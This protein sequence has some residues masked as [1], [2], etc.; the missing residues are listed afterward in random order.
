MIISTKHKFIF[1]HIPKT[2]GTSIKK[3]LAPFYN[4]KR[5]L[6]KV[7]RGLQKPGIIG[8]KHSPALLLRQ[9]VGATVWK[10]Y[11][12]FAFVR[13]PWDWFVSAYHF[14]RKNGRDPRQP[15]VLKRS[16][17]DFVPWFIN[18]EPPL[19]QFEKPAILNGQHWYVMNKRC[20]YMINFIG[21]LETFQEDFS[22]V[23][24][25]IGISPQKLG[26]HNATNRAIY[27]NY[28]N[29]KNKELIAKFFK[30]DIELFNYKF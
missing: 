3:A 12:T 10:A 13:N 23:C 4:R 6:E 14:M 9:A 18:L 19:E 22:K 11:F 29:E 17:E 2:G 5:E 8:R 24:K 1:I 27:K 30:K 26:K 16:F 7:P 21:K 28:Y 20:K 15:E 25:R